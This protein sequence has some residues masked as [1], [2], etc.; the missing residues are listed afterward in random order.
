MHDR[1]RTGVSEVD[2]R[3]ENGEEGRE[4]KFFLL[5]HYFIFVLPLHSPRGR[6]SLAPVSQLL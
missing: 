1:A 2:G 6:A 5:N 3:A 4:R